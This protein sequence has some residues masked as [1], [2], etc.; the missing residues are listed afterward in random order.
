LDII[1]KV[2]YNF[3]WDNEKDLSEATRLAFT[4]LFDTGNSD[5]V[6]VANF[7]VGVCKWKDTSE[8]NDPIIEAKANSLR[9]VILAVKKQLNMKKVEEIIY[10]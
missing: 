7:L 4:N 8:C 6:L 3:E 9:N 1:D 2:T 10:E 5:A